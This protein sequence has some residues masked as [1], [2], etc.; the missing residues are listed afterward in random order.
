MVLEILFEKLIELFIPTN[1]KTSIISKY[2]QIKKL[3]NS[4]SSKLYEFFYLN[5]DNIHQ[6]LYETENIIIIPSN[7][8]EINFNQLFYLILLIKQQSLFTDFIYKFD[9]IKNINNFRKSN[10]NI[11]KSF[12]LSM[13]IIEL[14]KN[15]NLS[16]EYYDETYKSELDSISEE[17]EKIKNDYLLSNKNNFNLEKNEIKNN[18]LEYIYSKII[19]PLL[20]K[21]N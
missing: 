13:I 12:I 6:I 2:S 10:E 21:K 5:K 8:K 3:G 7:I 19:Y 4:K 9:Y 15:Y 1:G 20:R 18:D 11:L 17:N 16:D 14:I